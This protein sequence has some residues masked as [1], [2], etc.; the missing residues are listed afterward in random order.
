MD[1]EPAGAVALG[2]AIRLAGPGNGAVT[3]AHDPEGLPEQP[4]EAG[5]IDQ[6]Q[7][8]GEHL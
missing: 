1:R 5:P 8:L 2:G 7:Q 6:R 4:E 3:A